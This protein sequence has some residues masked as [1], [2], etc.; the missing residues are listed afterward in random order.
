MLLWIGALDIADCGYCYEFVNIAC[1]ICKYYLFFYYNILDALNIHFL[2][3][4]A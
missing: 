4:I 3:K 1:K 2:G